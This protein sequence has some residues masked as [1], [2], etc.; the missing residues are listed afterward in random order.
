MIPGRYH[1]TLTLDGRP[2]LHGWWESEPIARRQFASLVG[3]YGRPGAHVTLADEE[4]GSVLTEWPD[5][6]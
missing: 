3:Q 2:T 1:L 5:E 6:A 4:T